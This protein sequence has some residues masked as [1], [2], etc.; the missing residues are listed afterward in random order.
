MVAA[1]AFLTAPASGQA[2]DVVAS[3]FG[4]GSSFNHGRFWGVA[5]ASL[6]DQFVYGGPGGYF[7]DQIRLALVDNDAAAYTISFWRGPDINTA[8][9]LETWSSVAAPVDGGILSLASSVRPELSPGDVYWIAVQGPPS[10]PPG[11]W[12]FNDDGVTDALY[13]ASPGFSYHPCGNPTFC[14][15]GIGPAPAFDVT[16]SAPEPGSLALLAT[17]LL[18][19]AVPVVRRRRANQMHNGPRHYFSTRP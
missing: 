11:G 7:L 17:G 18:G 9:E 12:F 4:P 3:T 14:P 16:A 13:D 10:A 1:I 5:G 19:L 15:G 2:Q 6:A 8:V